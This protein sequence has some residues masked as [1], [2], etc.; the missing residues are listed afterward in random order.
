MTDIEMCDSADSDSDSEE[1]EESGARRGG[2]G[3]S[4]DDSTLT[5][6]IIGASCGG[7]CLIL[8]FGYCYYIGS[9]AQG[10]VMQ[11]GEVMYMEPHADPAPAAKVLEVETIGTEEFSEGNITTGSKPANSK[12]L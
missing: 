9:K 12:S 11:Q 5:A 2:R 6:I 8:V 1:N 7:C 3:G 4:D 10:E